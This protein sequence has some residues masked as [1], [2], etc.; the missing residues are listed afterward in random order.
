MSIFDLTGQIALVTG[1]SRGIGEEIAKLL[2][3]Y[4]AHVIVSSRKIDSCQRVADEII[5]DG[6]QAEAFPCHVGDMAEITAVF[7]HITETHGQLNI[8]INNAATNPYYGHILDTSLSAFEKTI[9]VN[10]RGYFFMSVEGGKIMREIGGGAIVN[11]ASV[12]AIRPGGQQ[13]IYSITKA[14]VMHMTKAFALECGQFGIRVNAI[15]PGLTRTKLAGAFF[16]DE[17]IYNAAIS[18]IPLGRGAEP[19]EQA[20]TGL[21]L[22]SPAASYVTGATIVV[23]GGLTL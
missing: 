8:L 19:S 15:L 11:T 18:K 10:M 20:G 7:T 3:K 14:A 5:A 6:G 23:D 22:V 4:G 16:E 2:A 12:H 9:E 21:Y 1:A 13:G 17:V